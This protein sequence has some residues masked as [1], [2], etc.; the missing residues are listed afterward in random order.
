MAENAERKETNMNKLEELQIM[1][2]AM[3]HMNNEDAYYK[4]IYEVPDEPSIDDF[5]YILENNEFDYVKKF[6]VKLLKKY[7]KDGLYDA[8]Q[9]V[10]EYTQQFCPDIVNIPRVRKNNGLY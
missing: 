1:H 5:E 8:P 4:W 6:F 9:S 7:A 10:Y 3:L 2:E